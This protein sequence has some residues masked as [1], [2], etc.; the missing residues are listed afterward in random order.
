MRN[1]IRPARRAPIAA[2]AGALTIVLAGIPAAAHAACPATPTTQAFK[3]FGDT[4]QYSPVSNG[5]FE[6]GTGGWSLTGASVMTG[7]EPWY[8]RSSSDR[9]SLAVP[10]TG[11]ATSPA[12]CVGIEHPTFRFVARRTNSSWGTL[13]VKLSWTEANGQKN[14]TTVAS[15]NGGDTSWHV[16]NPLAL[17]TT[18]PLS[19]AGQTLQVRLVFDPE[20]YG[21]AW[22]IDDIQ[23]DPFARG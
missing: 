18:L 16:T 6:S 7:N 19:D 10:A 22:A 14:T 11:L 20:D 8:I 4:A 23:V 15:I 13:N 21:G 3:A 2:L 1:P 17:A 12:I 5:H 9:K